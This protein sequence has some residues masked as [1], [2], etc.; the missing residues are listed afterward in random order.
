MQL[1]KPAWWQLYV[2]VPLMIGLVFV[3]H[4]DPLPGVSPEIVDGMIVLLT[5]GAMFVW[6]HVNGSAI[7]Y[8]E[9]QRNGSHRNLKITIYKLESAP[10]ENAQGLSIATSLAPTSSPINRVTTPRIGRADEGKW[11]LN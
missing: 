11:S 7:E 9:M 1:R 6:M 8:D 3:E 4:L 10:A 2:L 5:F